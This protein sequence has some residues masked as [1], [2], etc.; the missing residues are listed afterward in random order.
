M[1]T[2]SIVRAHTLSHKAAR[3][4][5]QHVVEDLRKRFDLAYEWDGDDVAFE[6]PGVSGR[7]HVG[8]D[9]LA[10]E[11]KLG[12]LLGALKSTVEREINAQLDTLF[13]TSPATAAPAA[14]RKP[15]PGAKPSTGAAAKAPAR[16]AARKP[17]G[18]AKG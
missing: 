14:A 5:A 7:M 15:K 1:P 18:R 11:V 10:L 3:Q 8:R 4:A 2:I 16:P 9:E 13:P 17:S 6:R 12:L